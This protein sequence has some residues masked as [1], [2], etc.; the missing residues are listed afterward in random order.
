MKFLLAVPVLL[1][2]L[3]AIWSWRTSRR[4]RALGSILDKAIAQLPAHERARINLSGLHDD[5]HDD[6][7]PF[8]QRPR[9]IMTEW[10]MRPGDRDNRSFHD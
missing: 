3:I 4:T 10:D 5:V 7:E 6:D 9:S 1:V 8:A 2:L